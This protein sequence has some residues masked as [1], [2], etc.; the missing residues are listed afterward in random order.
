[1][2]NRRSIINIF[3][4]TALLLFG[5][6]AGA[7]NREKNP[8]G[9]TSYVVGG[10]DVLP[11]ELQAVAALVPAGETQYESSFCSG[12]LVDSEWVLTAAHCAIKRTCSQ[13]TRKR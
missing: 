12:I 1:M 6:L 10:E 9:T 11:D 13:R 2:M 4:L 7:D 8:D 5:T 3:L